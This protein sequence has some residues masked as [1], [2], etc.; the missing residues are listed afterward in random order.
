MLEKLFLFFSSKIVYGTILIILFT[1]IIY[2]ILHSL[3]NKIVIKGKN[4]LEIKRKRTVIILFNNILKY[5]IILLMVLVLLDLYGI[6]TSSI[7]AGLGIAGVVLGFALQDAL[8]D[9]ING[10]TIIMD[11]YFVVGDYVDYNGFVGIVI[12]FG[13]KTTKIKKV[14]GE[15]YSISNRNI[16]KIINI[17]Q[18]K[19]KINIY[20]PT[21]YEEKY[22]KVERVL[23]QVLEE[24]KKKYKEVNEV[25]FLGIESLEDSY[26]K[27]L[28]YIKCER[29]TQWN[30]KRKI[31]KDIKLAYDKNNIK[32]PYNQLEV[33]N[34]A[35]L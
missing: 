34:G 32:I 16:D 23:K 5:I 8:K 18:E 28:L 20:V 10:I 24:A 35:K 22:E 17:S 31:L 2:K 12:E 29:E 4:D 3:L 6:D 19:S 30:L 26:I 14:T 9:I 15:I 11:N 27:Y 7:I 25:Q 21:A 13:L 1:F 33:H